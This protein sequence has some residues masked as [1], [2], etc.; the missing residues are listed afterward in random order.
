VSMPEMLIYYIFLNFY[1]RFF[2][3]CSLMHTTCFD[4]RGVGLFFV[5]PWEVYLHANN[6]DFNIMECTWTKSVCIWTAPYIHQFPS[7]KMGGFLQ[8]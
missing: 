2:P 4:R 1:S 7:K 3:C 8:L 6:I 5:L